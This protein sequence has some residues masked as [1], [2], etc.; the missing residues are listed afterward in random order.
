VKTSKNFVTA[1]YYAS[2]VA[3]GVAMSS[4]GP[5]LPALA[6]ATHSDLSGISILFAA[7]SLGSLAGSIFI[8][9]LYDRMRGNLVMAVMIVLM[10]A[11]SAL[12]PYVPLLWLLTG[13]LFFTGIVQGVLNIGGNTLLVWL[14]GD[15]VGPFMNGLHFCFGVGTF[16]TP[17][18]IAQFIAQHGSLG[19]TYL[20]LAVIMLPTAAVAFLPSPTSPHATTQRQDSQPLDVWLIVLI[21]LVFGLY[22]GVAQAF[23]GYIF[24]YALKTKLAN[25]VNAAY[26]TSVF[27][28][29]LTLG[30]LAAIPIAMRYKPQAILKADFAGAFV[31]LLVMLTWPRSLLAVSISS[32]GLGFALASIYPTTMSLSG[33][34]MVLS[35]RITGLFSVGNSIG[36][37]AIPWI[38]GQLFDRFGPQSMTIVFLV[39]LLVA[40]VVLVVLDRY[41][42]RRASLTE[43]AA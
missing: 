19:M 41:T 7:R 29:A 37:M 25:E 27:W 26:L 18:I 11:F 15:A 2:F 10:A 8:S 6:T 35:A 30:R 3:M 32:A 33:R 1:S 40:L 13:L 39:D 5:T 22:S 42:V 36:M 21:S 34:L 23:G 17:I 43:Q 12:T 9:R 16:I 31:S 38:I 4:L 24:T 14:H 28:G 20:L